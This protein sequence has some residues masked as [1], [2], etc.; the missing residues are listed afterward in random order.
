MRLL[1]IA[2]L[3]LAVSASSPGPAGAGRGMKKGEMTRRHEA[4]H[5]RTAG[6]GHRT[7]AG[8]VID[9]LELAAARLVIRKGGATERHWNQSRSSGS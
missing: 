2:S 3:M 6:T 9:R 7:G 1:V 5:A 4:C 8:R